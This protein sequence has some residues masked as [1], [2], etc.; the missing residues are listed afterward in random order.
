MSTPIKPAFKAS[1]LCPE[2]C[3]AI[4]DP[5][6]PAGS[7][8]VPS[9]VALNNDGELVVGEEARPWVDLPGRGVREVKR[10]MGSGQ[11][12]RLGEKDYRPEE[13]AAVILRKLRQQAE[14][15]LGE[16]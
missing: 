9:L 4:A 14:A 12:V 6:S 5:A 1:L 3:Q 16:P 15:G 11:M 13:I 7:P 2:A 10:L 8:I